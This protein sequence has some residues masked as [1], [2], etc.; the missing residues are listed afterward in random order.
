MAAKKSEIFSTE[1]KK[2]TRREESESVLLSRTRLFSTLARLEVCYFY[3]VNHSAYPA[4]N[5]IS[6]SIIDSLYRYHPT[7]IALNFRV[8]VY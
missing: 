3:R 1:R 2:W 5:I 6:T 4:S 8:Y 7:R